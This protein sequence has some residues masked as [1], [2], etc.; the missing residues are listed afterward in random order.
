MSTTVNKACVADIFID[1]GVA[2]ALAVIVFPGLLLSIPPV[3]RDAEHNS[4]A[5]RMFVTGKFTFA[6]AAV[7]A[8]VF[9]LL[10]GTYKTLMAKYR[11]KCF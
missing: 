2:T 9:F 3:P 6:S 4:L 11:S 1:T 8:L 5:S 10:F 7:H